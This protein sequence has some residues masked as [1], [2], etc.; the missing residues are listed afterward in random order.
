MIKTITRE[1]TEAITLSGHPRV[2]IPLLVCAM[3]ML[4]VDDVAGSDIYRAA[5]GCAA[6]ALG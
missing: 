1:E 2:R 3:L 6:A 5:I 4:E